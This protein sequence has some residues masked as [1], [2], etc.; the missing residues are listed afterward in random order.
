MAGESGRSC[1]RRVM[2]FHVPARSLLE[3]LQ[4]PWLRRLGEQ[5]LVYILR[6]VAARPP[7]DDLLAILLPLQDRARSDAKPP[8]DLSRYGDL[9]LCGEFRMGDRH[10][11]YMNL[12]ELAAIG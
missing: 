3:L 7:D 5:R 9:A 8:A 12:Y 4:L 1:Q 11:C 10:G 2:G 6:C